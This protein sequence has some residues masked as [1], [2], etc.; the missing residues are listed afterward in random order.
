MEET[1][2]LRLAK[3]IFNGRP[4]FARSKK[5]PLN[6]QKEEKPIIN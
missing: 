2:K 6:S 3:G 4:N 1:S 5:D